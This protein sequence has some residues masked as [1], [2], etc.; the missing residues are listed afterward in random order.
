MTFQFERNNTKT[1]SLFFV[2]LHCEDADISFFCG[3]SELLRVGHDQTTSD[4]PRLTPPVI[5]LNN[6]LNPDPAYKI[7]TS[8]TVGQGR[9]ATLHLA[10]RLPGLACEANTAFGFGLWLLLLEV[11]SP[12]PARLA[13]PSGVFESPP[14][15]YKH[16][17][18]RTPPCPFTDLRIPL[19]GGARG[20]R[21]VFIRR[22][23]R[24]EKCH[25]AF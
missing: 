19:T 6:S 4:R 18:K 12:P 7:P 23:W 22:D 9:F 2:F 11:S 10:G 15:A 16:C 17:S 1:G 3:W 25:E 14:V 8:P 13:A 5:Y 21:S 24:H 20:V